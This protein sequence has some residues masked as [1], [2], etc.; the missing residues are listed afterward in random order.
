[1]LDGEMNYDAAP[2]KWPTVFDYLARPVAAEIRPA[3]VPS[4]VFY[5]GN[6]CPPGRKT[7]ANDDSDPPKMLRAFVATSSTSPATSAATQTYYDCASH[8]VVTGQPYLIDVR[9]WGVE[10]DAIIERMN[11]DYRLHYTVRSTSTS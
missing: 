6:G 11:Y 2:P 3:P 7:E 9:V 10:S 8:A 4:I 5:V 1:M